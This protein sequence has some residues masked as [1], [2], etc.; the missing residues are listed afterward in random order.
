MA[1]IRDVAKRAGV[2]ISTVSA[3]F[4]EGR[5]GDET[6]RR[7][8]EAAQ[9]VGYAPNAIAQSLKNGRSRLIAFVPG[10]IT[11]PF[12]SNWLIVVEKRAAAAN[13]AVI[14]SNSRSPGKERVTLELLKA[15]R[16]AGVLIN[17]Q[18]MG[19]E[20]RRYLEQLAIP[21]VTFDQYVEGLARDYVGT[22]NL[23]AG[24]M[25][26][27]YLLRL[28]HRRIAF[29]GGTPGLWTA[30]Q[31]A[32]GFI[33]AMS[34]AGAPIEPSFVLNADYD[35]RNAYEQTV[36]LM[37]GAELPTAILAANNEMALGAL[38]AINDLGFRCPQDVSLTTIDDVPWMGLV[39]PR[40]TLAVQPLQELAAIA[41]DWLLER[42]ESRDQTSIPPRRTIL[43]P[44][45]ILGESCADLR[46]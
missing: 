31:R 39:K 1:T 43:P 14:V 27:E 10:D 17:P 12:F 2:S 46:A 30:D 25:L 8:A 19:E 37:T 5:V 9:A 38:Q 24:K 7:I 11:N 28:G 34:R 45:I 18:G 41:I 33:S 22:D 16:V 29:I 32:E 15:Q 21:M 36:R 40:L 26:T 4:N 35:G 20:Y 6:K 23:L 13:R 44:K 42:I 3:A